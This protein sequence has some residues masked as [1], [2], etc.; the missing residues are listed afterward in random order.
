MP[1]L[2]VERQLT[3]QADAL[4]PFDEGARLTLF[5][6]AEGFEPGES[7]KAEAVVEFGHV[8]VLGLQVS[9]APEHVGAFLG[10]HTGE[11]RELVPRVTAMYGATHGFGDDAWLRRL[12]VQ[13]RKFNFAGDTNWL[14]GEVVGKEK[15]AEGAEVHLEI[16]IENQRGLTLT[17]G[18]AVILLPSRETGPVVLPSPPSEDVLGVLRNEVE[19]LRKINE[20]DGE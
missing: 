19:E 8:D 16:R 20:G 9:P 6:K 2:C 4:A 15:T 10:R 17:S 5:A 1:A 14:L 13:H 11:V 7:E 18:E 3:V 12:H